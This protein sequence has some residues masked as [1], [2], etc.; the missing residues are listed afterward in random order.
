MYESIHLLS[1]TVA[2]YIVPG[3]FVCSGG[4]QSIDDINMA[5]LAG[6]QEGRHAM[7]RN[8]DTTADHHDLTEL[9]NQIIF[10][11]ANIFIHTC[12]GWDEGSICKLRY[13]SQ[14][15][16]VVVPAGCP[17]LYPHPYSSPHRNPPLLLFPSPSPPLTL[18]TDHPSPRPWR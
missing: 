5:I 16:H 17:G 15:L 10:I 12:M 2:S 8:T 9:E 6:E 11:H 7:L 18:A 1:V 3:I 14:G 13:V 4:Q